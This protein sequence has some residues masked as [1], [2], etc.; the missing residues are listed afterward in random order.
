LFIDVRLSHHNKWLLTYLLT[1]L[2]SAVPMPV[3]SCF[4]IASLLAVS[5]LPACLKQS[6]AKL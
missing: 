1:Y 6:K 5:R 2:S 3:A 4:I